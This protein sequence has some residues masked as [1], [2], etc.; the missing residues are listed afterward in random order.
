MKRGTFALLD[1]LGFKGIW[2]RYEHQLLMA[3]LKSISEHAERAAKERIYP[4]IIPAEDIIYDV[5]VMLLS[6]TVAVSLLPMKDETFRIFQLIAMTQLIHQLIKVFIKDQPHLPLRGCITYGEHS[7]EHNFFIGPAVDIVAE[8]LDSA[9]G[10]FVWF[11]P[12][13]SEILDNWFD[14][15]SVGSDADHVR[16]LY[17]ALSPKYAVPMKNGNYLTT[18][19]INPFQYNEPN[20]DADDII[21]LYKDYMAGD[22]IDIWIKRENTLKF[23]ERCKTL[24][25]DAWRTANR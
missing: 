1:C 22:T 8:Y 7:T 23:L 21:Q 24:S 3:K 13:D 19:L 16:T 5:R 11:L 10:A 6:D 4:E 9:Q 25:R 20:D 18:R 14:A 2:K 15:R 17:E 12:S